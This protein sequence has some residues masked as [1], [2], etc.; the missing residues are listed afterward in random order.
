MRISFTVRGKP[1]GKARPRFRKVGEKVSTYTPK[2]T[3]EYENAVRAAYERQCKNKM[4]DGAVRA[5]ITAYFPIPK[6]DS[7]G[8]R[9]AKL[10]GEIKHTVKPDG[11]N[12]AKAIL[13][14]LNGHAYKDDSRVCE[15]SVRKL[16]SENPR[17]VV[18]LEEI[19]AKN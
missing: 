16:Y 19:T 6:S 9:A 4:L 18:T 15:L 1:Q 11:D 10:G 13:D 2:T 14:S 3:V 5:W 17:V 7:K 8:K 12:V